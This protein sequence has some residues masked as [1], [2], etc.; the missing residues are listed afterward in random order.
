[1]IRRSDI[2]V[3]PN[4]ST[5]QPGIYVTVLDADGE[6]A[7]I[8]DDD[9][10][11]AANPLVTDVAGGFYYNVAQAGAY[12]EEFR[13]S[14]LDSPRTTR[15]V[16]LG[17]DIDGGSEPI[18]KYGASVTNSAAENSVALN[19]A[20]R[21]VL[22]SNRSLYIPP[23]TFNFTTIDLPENSVEGGRRLLLWGP[24]TLRTT[25]SGF[26]ITCSEGSFFD[27]VCQGLR[28]ESVPNSGTRLFD[29][30]AFLRLCI[31][32]CQIKDFDY[33]IKADSGYIQSLRLIGNI[34]RGGYP[35]GAVVKTPM[36]YD[37]VIE[38]NIIEYVWD[39]IVID[40]PG[41][42]ANRVNISRNCIEGIGGRAVVL[43]ACLATSVCDN[44]LEGNTGGDLFFNAGTDSHQ[45]LRVQSNKIELSAGRLAQT[46][47]SFTGSISGTTL[48]ITAVNFGTLAVGT[49]IHGIGIAPGTIIGAFGTGSGGTGTYILASAQTVASTTIQSGA[50][51][52]VWG[53][54]A[55]VPI[56]SGGN[57]CTGN[58]HET[59][60]VSALMDMLGDKAGGELYTGYR[61]ENVSARAPVG[62]ATYASDTVFYNA[63]NERYL[64]VDPY[65]QELSFGGKHDSTTGGTD[66]PPVISF[67]TASPQASPG[68]YDRVKWAK[69]SVVF[70]VAPAAAGPGYWVCTTA[71]SPGTW[72]FVGTVA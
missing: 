16:R 11:E 29:G 66:E 65:R 7:T 69:G 13:L 25:Y 70:N 54:S 57:Q 14:L 35:F 28:F 19:A 20:I 71:G 30:N 63:Y 38:Q 22:L 46:R 8:Y 39:G 48:T 34:I 1:M 41:I 5:P 59:T 23:G 4:G 12:T 27:L 45:G 37:A 44:Y 9:G 52:I 21:A 26:A 32:G 72:S 24:G 33:V 15:S 47:G 42:A 50:F 43:G 62:W 53:V 51:G 40:G 36:A 58:L 31:T 10:D 18:T 17:D 6:L 68:N 3:L 55:M 67:G 64:G 61:I 56:R 2:T 60:G 49:N